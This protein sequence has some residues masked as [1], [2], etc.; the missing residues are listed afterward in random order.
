MYT[1]VLTGKE[2]KRKRKGGRA[3][4]RREGEGGKTKEES[5][6]GTGRK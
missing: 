2:K 1:R 5:K 3:G 4:K 6:S